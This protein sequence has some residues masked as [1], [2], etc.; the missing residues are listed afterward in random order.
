MRR[1]L[2][3]TSLMVALALILAASHGA[4]ITP[5]IGG[6]IGQFDGGIS[7]SAASLGPQPTGKILLVD[8]VSHLLQIDG[9]SRVCLAGGC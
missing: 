8:G 2:R 7:Q 6:G 3:I 9:V 1:A 5:Q 4:T